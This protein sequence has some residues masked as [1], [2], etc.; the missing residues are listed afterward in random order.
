MSEETAT[1]AST[2]G[3]T[4][5]SNHM[6]TLV[7]TFDPS[8]DDLEQYT[9]KVELLSEIWPATKINELI[10]RLILNTSGTAFQKLQLNNPRW[11]MTNDKKGVQLLVQLL[12]GQWGK[13]NL[14]KKYDIV[15]RALFRCLQKQDESND[16]FLARCDV[17]WSE[18]VQLE[19][20]QSYIVLRGSRL[21][22]EDKKRVIVES[23]SSSSGVLNMEK[24]TQSVRMLGTSFFNEM[25]GQKA[26]KG[27]IYESQVMLTE[28]QDDFQH[29]ESA[30]VA[31]EYTEDEFVGQLLQDDDED[32]ALIADYESRAADVLQGEVTLLPHTTHTQ[33][34]GEDS[35]TVSSIED[36]GQ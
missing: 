26:S 33:M 19:E 3:N 2:D 18:L 34:P 16:S 31:D 22:T 36:F 12:G 23:E 30:D 32:A 10:T 4:A 7:P 11:M 6:A 15:E 29:D 1:A 14:E 8:K 27:K 35:P 20:I 24:V 5:S 9:Q 28:D 13:V 25:I 17:V 21:S